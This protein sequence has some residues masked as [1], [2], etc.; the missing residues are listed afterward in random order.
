[1]AISC[2]IQLHPD[3]RIKI[4]AL[5]TAEGGEIHIPILNIVH[6][7]TEDGRIIFSGK[8][9]DIFVSE[10]KGGKGFGSKKGFGA[11]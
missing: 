3:R 8:V 7:E 10:K 11:R 1:M 4:V 5:Q 2:G 9:C 6:T